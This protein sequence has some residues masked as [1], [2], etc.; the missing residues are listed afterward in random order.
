MSS[1]YPTY[2]QAVVIS[3][4]MK[5]WCNIK[6]RFNNIPPRKGK[7]YMQQ[8]VCFWE[9]VFLFPLASKN[10]NKNSLVVNAQLPF[11]SFPQILPTLTLFVGYCRFTQ[12][13]SKKMYTNMHYYQ[14][15]LNILQSKYTVRDVFLYLQDFH[16][17]ESRF[18]FWKEKKNVL[19]WISIMKAYINK[20]IR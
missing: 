7:S 16:Y 12:N 1:D 15:H 2:C 5:R 6:R 18:Y 8:S 11:Y 3:S 4:S 20:M 9:C 13:F 14:H 17:H 19:W 10:N